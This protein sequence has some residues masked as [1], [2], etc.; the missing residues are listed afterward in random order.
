MTGVRYFI[1]QSNAGLSARFDILDECERP[2]YKAIDGRSSFGRRILLMDEN[3]EQLAQIRRVLGLPSLTGY[4]IHAGPKES[5]RLFLNQ[6]ANQTVLS[7]RGKSWHFRGDIL[8]RSFDICD[9]DSSVV[10]THSRVWGSQCET[11]AAEI[12]PECHKLLCICLAIAVDDIV[13]ST[14]DAAQPVPVITK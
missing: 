13:L 11:Y 2:C 12:H 7:S 6:S 1:R 10:M 14:G 3:G 8:T 9:V 5:A 4:I